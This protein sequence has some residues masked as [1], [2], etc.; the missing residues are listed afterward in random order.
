MPVVR[1]EGEVV[2]GGV[3]VRRSSGRDIFEGPGE[4]KANVFLP[5]AVRVSADL[6]A[7]DATG[8]VGREEGFED[9]DMR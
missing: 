1:W 9:R 2:V 5:E 8:I 6:L 3:Q 4:T 7:R